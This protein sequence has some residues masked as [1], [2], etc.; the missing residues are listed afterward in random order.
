MFFLSRLA[1]RFPW[2]TKS[3]FFFRIFSAFPSQYS[4]LFET[5]CVFHIGAGK[6]NERFLYHHTGVKAVFWAE[7]SPQEYASCLKNLSHFPHQYVYNMAIGKEDKNVPFHVATNPGSSSFL[8]LKD[9]TLIYP[10]I[11]SSETIHLDVLPFD[12]FINSVNRNH[13]GAFSENNVNAIVM[14]IQGYELSALQ[15]LSSDSLSKFKYIL[16]E[17]ANFEAYSG[18]PL[19]SEVCSY[20]AHHKIIPISVVKKGVQVRNGLELWFSDTLFLNTLYCIT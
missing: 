1:Y 10:A 14:D 2:L 20:L 9:H 18:Q 17:T 7:A 5:D 13:P 12:Y 16:L 6:G 19:H 4:F 8:N 11:K 3:I 15:S